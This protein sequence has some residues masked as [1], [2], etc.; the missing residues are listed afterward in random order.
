[1]KCILRP[2]QVSTK[3]RGVALLVKN[4]IHVTRYTELEPLN[5]DMIVAICQ[6]AG[7]HYFICSAYAPPDGTTR[8]SSNHAEHH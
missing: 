8:N 4:D 5:A 7:L 2:N 6:I 3:Q 1:M